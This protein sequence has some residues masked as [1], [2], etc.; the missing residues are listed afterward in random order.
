M[1]AVLVVLAVL[2]AAPLAYAVVNRVFLRIDPDKTAPEIE[3]DVK[4]QLE[5]A[6]VTGADVHA[7]KSDDGKLK[8]QIKAENV[9]SDV[10]IVPPPN[11]D[12]DQRSV[13]VAVTM[14]LTPEQQ[15]KLAAAMKS[16]DVVA[17]LEGDLEGDDLGAALTDALAKHGIVADVEVDGKATSIKITAPPK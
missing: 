15:Q 9:G 10:E 4:D 14:K 16:D 11:A 5:S 7:E 12:A 17:L 1:F 13:R 8:V 3:K 6:G 2:L